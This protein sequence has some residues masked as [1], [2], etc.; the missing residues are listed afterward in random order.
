MFSVGEAR[1]EGRSLTPPKTTCEKEIE[2]DY[3]NKSQERMSVHLP[4]VATITT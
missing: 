3:R 2:A 1:G 4:T